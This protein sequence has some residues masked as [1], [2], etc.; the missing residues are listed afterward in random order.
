MKPHLA[1]PV[2]C[3]FVALSFSPL[4]QAEE[5]DPDMAAAVKQAEEQA[6]KMGLKMPDM[7]A[8][9]AEIEADEAKEKTALKKQLEAPG[10]IAF[11][12]WTPKTPDF[13]PDGPPA[14]KI[15]DEEVQI[16]QTGTSTLTPAD[17]GDAWEKAGGKDLSSGRSNNSINDTKTVI[18]YLTNM[19]TRD[20]VRLEATRAPKDKATKVT[21]SSPLPKPE[22]D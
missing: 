19:E 7:K 5:P 18:I 16:I 20:K 1:A 12:A 2:L 4:A 6:T 9:M 21:I 3:L 22:I 10:P 15:V 13:T 8:Q 14:K 11:P 17:L